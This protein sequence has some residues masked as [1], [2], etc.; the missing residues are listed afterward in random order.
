LF[1]HVD[2]SVIHF[3]KEFERNSLLTNVNITFHHFSGDWMLAFLT[4][5][6]PLFTSINC[7]DIYGC[8]WNSNV[9]LLLEEEYREFTMPMLTSARILWAGSDFVISE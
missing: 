3:L 5:V 7:L 1:S 9:R 2:D 4:K 8:V 6:V